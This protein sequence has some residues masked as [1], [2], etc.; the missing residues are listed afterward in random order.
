[1]NVEIPWRVHTGRLLEELGDRAPSEVRIPLRILRALLAR[2][3]QEA[4]RINDKQ[5]NALM[6]RLTLYEEAD[7]HVPGYSQ[8]RYERVLRE[9]EEE[10]QS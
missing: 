6:M 8:E 9:A 3:A 2:V 5:L 7:P 4:I 1:M 10:R